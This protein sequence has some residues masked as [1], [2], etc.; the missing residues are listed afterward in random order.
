MGVRSYMAFLVLTAFAGAIPFATA[1]AD[2]MP[3]GQKIASYCL[4]IVGTESFPNLSFFTDSRFIELSGGHLGARLSE[5]RKDEFAQQL[6]H[7]PFT[8]LTAEKCLSVQRM[9]YP[10]IYAIRNSDLR[11]GQAFDPE[12][13]GV[14]RDNLDFSFR[15]PS[16]SLHLTERI[17]VNRNSDVELVTDVLAVE[18]VADGVITLRRVHR[19]TRYRDGREEISQ[20]SL[21]ADRPWLPASAAAAVI[22]LAAGLT[23]R[24]RRHNLPPPRDTDTP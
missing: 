6:G 13:P 18:S 12:D 15:P 23:L 10:R 1:L 4:E 22:S 19:R 5:L 2:V 7:D 21:V 24:R 14:F 16:G 9:L 11:P 17:Y 20:T 3:A 8:P